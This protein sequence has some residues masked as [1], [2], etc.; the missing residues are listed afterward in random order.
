MKVN[1]PLLFLN[2]IFSVVVFGIVVC[3]TFV[4]EGG[5]G[6]DLRGVALSFILTTNPPAVP[7]TTGSPLPLIDKTGET[8]K[9]GRRWVYIARFI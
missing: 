8:G 3:I 2:F 4:Q 5:G 1:C 9:A 6:E 7:L